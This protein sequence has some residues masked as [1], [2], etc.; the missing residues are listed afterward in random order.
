[1]SASK[2]LRKVN[3]RLLLNWRPREENTWADDL[4]NR[5]FSA[6]DPRRRVKLTLA[7]LPLEMLAK[8]DS[9]RAESERARATLVSLKP[10]DAAMGRREKEATKTDW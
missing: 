5:N 2:A 7:M 4:T 3:K 6:F 8:L 9:A 1:M 10:K